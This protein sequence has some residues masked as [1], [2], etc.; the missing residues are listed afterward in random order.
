MKLLSI[1]AILASASAASLQPSLRQPAKAEDKALRLRGGEVGSAILT[2]SAASAV[3][4]G[5]LCYLGKTDLASL[6]WLKLNEW[7][8]DKMLGSA[9]IG[10]GIGKWCAVRNGSEAVKSYCQLNCIPMTLMILAAISGGAPLKSH[11]LPAT[12]LAAYVYV[13]FLE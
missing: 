8:A 11:L 7:P 12:L 10:W 6:L 9:C 4:T 1:C 2:V 13:G 5:S 3:A